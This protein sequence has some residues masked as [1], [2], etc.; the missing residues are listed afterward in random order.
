MSGASIEIVETLQIACV[1][2]N[3]LVGIEPLARF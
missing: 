1:N 2:E 3:H